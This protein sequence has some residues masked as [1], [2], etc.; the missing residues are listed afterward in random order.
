MSIFKSPTSQTEKPEIIQAA[1]LNKKLNTILEVT[2]AVNENISTQSLYQLFQLVITNQTGVKNLQYY[3][4]DKIWYRA[5]YYGEN[6]PET[7]ISKLISKYEEASELS[8]LDKRKHNGIK[9]IIPIR[10]RSKIVAVVLAGNFHSDIEEDDKTLLNFVQIISNIIAVSIENQKLLKREKDRI[11]LN[12]ELEFAS[13]IQHILVPDK[14]PSN[15]LYEFAG[16]YIPHHGIGGD[17]YDVFN[18]SKNEIVFCIADISGKGIAA[19]LLMANLQAYLNAQENIELG[20]K[21]IKKLNNKV[22]NITNGENFIT[23]FIAK[24]NM[25]NKELQ[26]INAGHNPPLLISSDNQLTPLTEGCTILGIFEQIENL[27]IGMVKLK[28][29]DTIVCYTDGLTEL[30][31]DNGNQYSYKRLE[32]FCR[33]NAKLGPDVFLKTLHNSLSK[34]K[35]NTLFDDD[36]SILC[37]KIL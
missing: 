7:D 20:E 31:N 30:K 27:K 34:F 2:R 24:Y 15:T 22:F 33:E 36:I 1:L 8:F 16:L 17:Y 28:P 23:L 9:Y 13:K 18:I 10:H 29:N 25:I 4:F 26:Y 35:G 11:E 21:F 5:F 6:E 12:K 37:C 19:A 32:Q 3:A 14:L